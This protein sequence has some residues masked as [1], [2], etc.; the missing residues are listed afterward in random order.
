M[1][2][3]PSRVLS[4][5]DDGGRLESFDPD[6]NSLVQ[7]PWSKGIAEMRVFERGGAPHLLRFYEIGTAHKHQALMRLQWRN[8]V[9]AALRLAHRRHPS[10][11]RLVDAYFY[12]DEGVGFVL[13]RENGARL[14]SEGHPL[15]ERF[16]EEP[17]FAF[18]RFLALLEGLAY[19]HEEGIIHRFVVP[20]A[21]RARELPDEY[22][23]LD[24]FILSSFVRTWLRERWQ[25]NQPTMVKVETVREGFFLPPERHPDGRSD[26]PE[27]TSADVFGLGM[28]GLSW[29]VLP[30]EEWPVLGD[31]YSTEAQQELLNLLHEEARATLPKQLAEALVTATEFWPNARPNNAREL[32]E[33]LR[34]SRGAILS[35]LETRDE[36]AEP[37]QIRY[38]QETMEALNKG[39]FVN[40]PV[41]APGASRFYQAFIEKDLYQGQL[42]H[43]PSGFY[44]YA[45]GERNE[46]MRKA[47][48]VLLGRECVYFCEYLKLGRS[49]PPT[50]R[51]LI[52]KYVT[53]GEGVED[54]RTQANRR[55]LPAEFA[56]DC[57]TPG[58]RNRPLPDDSPSWAPLV[59]SVRVQGEQ[60]PSE[61]VLASRWRLEVEE[62]RLA[63]QTYRYEI[64]ET[65]ETSYDLRCNEMDE[66][67]GGAFGKLL[68]RSQRRRLMGQYFRQFEK[69]CLDAGDEPICYVESKAGRE[70]E[71]R[72]DKILDDST[73]RVRRDPKTVLPQYG[74]IAPE[75]S[76]TKAQLSR[77]NRALQKLLEEGRYLH[78]QLRGPFSLR[79]PPQGEL[80]FASE[81]LSPDTKSLIETLVTRRPLFVLQ[82]PP[83][84]GKSFTSSEAIYSYLK[85]EP[86]DRVLISAQSHYA[87]DHLLESIVGR[88]E[89]DPNQEFVVIRAAS[90]STREKL[91]TTAKKYVVEKV[92]ERVGN[93]IP[94]KVPEELSEKL[95][96]LAKEWRGVI[97]PDNTSESRLALE[98]KERLRESASVV[99]CTTNSALPRRLGIWRSTSFFDWAIIEE[100]AKGW[101]TEILI[102]AVR[103]VSWLLVGDHKQ[104]PAFRADELEELLEIDM[105]E[106]I[107]AEETG[108]VPTVEWKAWL[109][110]FAALM[111]RGQDGDAVH[112]L[113]VQRRM[114]PEIGGLVSEVF[115]DGLVFSHPSTEAERDHGYREPRWLEG[116]HVVWLDTSK[117]AWQD[118]SPGSLAN[119]CE[120]HAIRW[121]LMR[122]LTQERQF[123]NDIPR[124]VILSP[125]H[126]QRKA[127]ERHMKKIGNP[128]EIHTVDSFQGRQAE[129]VIVSMVR[130]N[131]QRDIGFMSDPHRLNVM[132][133]RARR[134][135]VL[136]GNL[137]HF[138]DAAAA[139]A[140]HGHV[141]RLAK[142]LREHNHVV[143]FLE[144]GF[145]APGSRR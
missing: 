128:V 89:A 66:E 45:D 103:S 72:L 98:V 130:S 29:L 109:R 59:E 51:A 124:R 131:H 75:S 123:E 61:L 86:F 44:G 56:V 20:S 58:V 23:I 65:R 99:F 137:P 136:V 18:R 83:G 38:L 52:I 104:L 69:E 143:D 70:I 4:L 112:T 102:P 43:S 24:G 79:I 8:E 107:T 13:L 31:K 132:L 93:A 91:S 62:A 60:E 1:P 134:L 21:I 126:D 6:V 119:K 133:S 33:S 49:K 87:L 71:L 113:S 85:A 81:E 120:Q 127:L 11:P 50:P 101:L 118:E 34:N 55:V 15:R 22:P 17:A 114:H 68:E 16:A 25:G 78:D 37:Y 129:E 53:W 28:L 67:C 40:K 19:L 82:G 96:A 108:I 95:Q 88:L 141:K 139:H 35:V 111:E 122:Y 138:E 76:G 47:Q 77:Q 26:L 39:R 3:I 27:G 2:D 117:L 94:S 5:F 10:L 73:I 97:K 80:A 106:E 116:R 32:L 12:E 63:R 125:Y 74:R 84:T 115:Y 42:I 41:T 105:A 54:L 90:E 140:E 121:L 57:Y 9:M 46:E 64:V 30:H 110:Y 135:L 144:I 92:L 48:T 145:N 14:D 36:P 142:Y 100:A 7:V